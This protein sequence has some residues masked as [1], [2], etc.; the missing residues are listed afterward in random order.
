MALVQMNHYRKFKRFR[1]CCFCLAFC[2][3]KTAVLKPE[4]VWIVVVSVKANVLRTSQIR[5]RNAAP[6]N[7]ARG[8]ARCPAAIGARMTDLTSRR[9]V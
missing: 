6:I 1:F 2:C 8:V 4:N 3:D 9:L 7:A 5:Q